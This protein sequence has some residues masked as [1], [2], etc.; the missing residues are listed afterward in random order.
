MKQKEDVS[1]NNKVPVH[2][3]KSKFAEAFMRVRI[4][5]VS[6]LSQNDRRN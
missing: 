2:Q 3:K 6:F 4:I 1:P 5:H